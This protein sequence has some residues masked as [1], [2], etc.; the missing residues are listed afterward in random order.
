MYKH[1]LLPMDDSPA[2][3]SAVRCGVR[4]AR[5]MHAKVTA[6][7]IEPPQRASGGGTADVDRVRDMLNYAARVAH[8]AGV[9]CS[10]IRAAGDQP[11][12]VIVSSARKLDC[13]LIVMASHRRGAVAALLFGSQTQQ[14]LAHCDLPVLVVS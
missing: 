14:V 2:S 13:D 5:Q 8:A 1:L 10:T 3:E 9:E 12:E 4:L 7:H 6:L 11:H